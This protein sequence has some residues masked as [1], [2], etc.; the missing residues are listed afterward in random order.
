MKYP[1]QKLN[2]KQVLEILVR[3]RNGERYQALAEVFGVTRR[4]I[5]DICRG[6]TWCDDE[7]I[8]RLRRM[9]PEHLSTPRSVVDVQALRSLY[10]DGLSAEKIGNTMGWPRSTI[11]AALYRN[12]ISNTRPQN[13]NRIGEA[14]SQAKLNEKDVIAILTMRLEGELT[15]KDIACMYGVTTT[16]IWAICAGKSWNHPDMKA[17]KYLRQKLKLSGINH[18]GRHM[19]K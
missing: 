18:T 10:E 19:K 3:R 11:E 17:I 16:T 15:Q 12:G 8:E 2:K 14:H 9:I 5:S 6:N 1:K 13:T 7:E 4:S